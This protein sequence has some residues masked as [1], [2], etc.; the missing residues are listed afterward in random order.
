MCIVICWVDSSSTAHE[1]ALGLVQ[2]PDTKALTLYTTIKELVRCSLPIA[3]CIGQA[4]DGAV[5]MSG[6]PNDVQV[7]MKKEADHCLYIHCFAESL[8]LCVQEVTKRCELVCNCMEFIFQLVQLIK[9][10]PKRL[11]LSECVRREITLSDGESAL[12]PSLRTLCPTRWTV[13]HSAIDSVM[14]IYQALMSSLLIIE[15]DDDEYAAKGKGLLMHMESFDTFFS[16][17]LAKLVFSAAEQF[18][19]TFRQKKRQFLKEPEV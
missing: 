3:S 5:N 11:N 18:P 2:L 10:S 6:V 13:R 9:F 7:L 14:K 8:N 4:Y 15:Q 17:K 16:L 19:Q 12:S 1:A